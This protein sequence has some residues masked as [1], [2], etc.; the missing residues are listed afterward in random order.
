MIT[1]KKLTKVYDLNKQLRYSALT[2][3]DLTIEDGELVAIVGQSGAGKSTLLHLLACID[4]PTSGTVTIDGVQTDKLSTREIAGIRNSVTSVVLQEFALL[5]DFSVF[6][7]VLLPLQ[8][9][10]GSI[11]EKKKRVENIL[12]ILKIDG[13]SKKHIN[14]LSG[15]QKQR[16]AIA[17]ALVTSPKY[18]FA[19]EPTGALDSTTSDEIMNVL[20]ELNR[21]GIT[22]VIVTHNTEIANRCNRIITLKDGKIVDM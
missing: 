2:N 8:F 20:F 13:L 15:G 10:K 4:T 5:E 17:R 11:R 14:Q 1:V 21:Q 12:E 7:N 6:D 19:D 9:S 22:M 18:I 3:V 16:V